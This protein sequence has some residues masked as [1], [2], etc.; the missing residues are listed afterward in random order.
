MYTFSLLLLITRSQI[1]LWH[2]RCDLC[3]HRCDRHQVRR[4]AVGSLWFSRVS[5]VTAAPQQQGSS[6]EGWLA[7]NCSSS[8]S[9]SA[10]STLFLHNKCP[11]GEDEAEMNAAFFFFFFKVI[12]VYSPFFLRNISVSHSFNGGSE[13]FPVNL[14]CFFSPDLNASSSSQLCALKSFAFMAHGKAW[15]EGLPVFLIFFFFCLFNSWMMNW[16]WEQN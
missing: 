14:V 7:G 8:S 11:W 1:F 13:P 12:Q 3:H 6:S 15:T 5:I 16:L 9:F 2:P 10:E 4:G